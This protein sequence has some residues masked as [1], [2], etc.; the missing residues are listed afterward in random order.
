[1]KGVGGVKI[2]PPPQKNSD[3]FYGW[4]PRRHIIS[5]LN[6]ME[7]DD[8]Y[9]FFFVLLYVIYLD[10]NRLPSCHLHMKLSSRSGHC[11]RGGRSE[12][13]GVNGLFKIICFFRT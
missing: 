7:N 5:S 10:D 9:Y 11:L 4:P 12:N 13:P 1:M 3:V 8:T 2:G 6:L